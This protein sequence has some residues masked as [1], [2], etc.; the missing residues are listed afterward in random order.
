M[1]SQPASYQ[2]SDRSEKNESEFELSLKKLMVKAR[3]GIPPK[4][5]SKSPIHLL[6]IRYLGM[7]ESCTS[8]LFF[9]FFYFL[10]SFSGFFFL[11]PRLPYLLFLF[12]F[13][14]PLFLF[15]FLFGLG[16]R[17]S[18]FGE[19]RLRL[20]LRLP[21]ERKGTWKGRYCT[22]LYCIVLHCTVGT[23]LYW[24]GGWNSGR[25]PGSAV[26]VV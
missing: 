6:P 20:R 21:R 24:T 26:A 16:E 15:L 8:L 2:T 14:F 18:S 4:Y 25:I 17:D 5:S 23:V 12:F 13:V 1:V 11:V 19:A 10:F 7:L 22:V 3:R 9:Y